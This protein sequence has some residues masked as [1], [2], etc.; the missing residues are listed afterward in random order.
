MSSS[1]HSQDS[2][3]NHNNS[4]LSTSV[5][6]SETFAR[7]RIQGQVAFVP[8]IT[9]GDPNLETTAEA[10][11]VLDSCGADIIE[12]GVPFSDPLADAARRAL[13]NGTNFDGIISMLKEVCAPSRFHLPSYAQDS[14]YCMNC[15]IS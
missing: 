8:Y 4:F 7:L 14:I 15:F 6:I 2:S 10:L 3:S 1:A 5:S 12:L 13:A 9:A 11:K